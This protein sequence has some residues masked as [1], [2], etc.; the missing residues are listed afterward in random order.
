MD[1]ARAA[2]I[3][4]HMALALWR[5]R[6]DGEALIARWVLEGAAEHHDLVE[7]RRLTVEAHRQHTAARRRYVRSLGSRAVRR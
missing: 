4:A 3:E 7:A 5:A 1:A 2:Y 6:Q